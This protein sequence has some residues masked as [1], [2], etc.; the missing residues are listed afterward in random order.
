MQRMEENIK[1]RAVVD[2]IVPGKKTKR[3]MDGLRPKGSP[4][5]MPR[6]E[7]SRNQKF[8]PQTPPCVKRRRG[9]EY[10]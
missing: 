7:H 1:M 9:R 3:D 8:G 10:H 4:Q 6:I 2:M 5:R